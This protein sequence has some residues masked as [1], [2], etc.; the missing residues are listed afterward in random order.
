[1]SASVVDPTWGYGE[2]RKFGAEGRRKELDR[3]EGW[4][5]AGGGEEDRVR[6]EGRKKV[7]NVGKRKRRGKGRRQG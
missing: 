3:T 1:M 2:N 5:D 7:G 4:E 6:Q